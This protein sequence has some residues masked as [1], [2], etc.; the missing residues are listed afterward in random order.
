MFY[1][2]YL[3]VLAYTNDAE[4]ANTYTE[5]DKS[6]YWFISIFVFMNWS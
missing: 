6:Q 5:N 3:K 2:K 4:N 1:V